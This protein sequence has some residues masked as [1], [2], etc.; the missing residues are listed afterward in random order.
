M[1]EM[2]TTRHQ[3][4]RKH[5]K[6]VHDYSQKSTDDFKLIIVNPSPRL[7]VQEKNCYELY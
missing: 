1:S 4:Q 3:L 7:T 2:V 6:K 5:Q